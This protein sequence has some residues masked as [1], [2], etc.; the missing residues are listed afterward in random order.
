M[1]DINFIQE[2][3]QSVIDAIEKKCMKVEI[4]D[5]VVTRSVSPH[6]F[7][8][9][10]L[11]TDN[12]RQNLRRRIDDLREAR[13]KLSTAIAG[14]TGKEKADLISK[15][16]Q[17]KGELEKYEPE[18]EGIER[19]FS[20]LMLRIPSVPTKDVPYGTSDADNIEIRKWGEIPKFDFEPKDHV[21]L[22]EILN[23]IDIPRGVK[24]A[25]TR[26]YFLKNEGALLELAITRFVLDRMVAKGFTP[27]LVPLIV[28]DEA[29]V[30]TGFFPGGEEQA[31]R[32]EKDKLNLIGTAEVSLTSYHSGEILS[33]DELPKL[34]VGFSA[35][36]RREAGTY[37]KDTRGVYRIHQFHKVEQVVICKNDSDVSREMHNF[38]LNN[39]EE[40]LQALGLPYRI[41]IVCSGEMGQ[42]QVYKN[43]IE[44]WIPSRNNYGETHSCSTL[45]DFQARRL[46]IKYKDSKGE[47]HFVHTLNNTVIASPSILIPILE[48]FQQSDG[49][50]L[51]PEV[52]RPYMN[53]KNRIE[54]KK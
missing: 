33:E 21:E 26:S 11:E 17:T 38:I 51:I 19:D 31:Y 54:P 24:I 29:M 45:H 39:S 10:L 46:N 32:I 53:G 6:E 18:L 34:Y 3:K 25:G 30:G 28:K 5:G 35:F 42:G 16:K 23:I 8:E 12:K 2:N 37:G 47:L 36:F 4:F 43:D 48:N 41:V 49:S 7:V 15:A 14:A 40:M 20:E 27:F 13:N 52:L 22:A 9:F 50:V 1:L 44:T